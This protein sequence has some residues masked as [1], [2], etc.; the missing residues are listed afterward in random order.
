MWLCHTEMNLSKQ[1]SSSYQI[2]QRIFQFLW[3]KDFIDIKYVLNF[4][5]QFWNLAHTNIKNLFGKFTPICIRKCP[6]ALYTKLQQNNFSYW[7]S[8]TKCL[9]HPT[10]IQF[11]IYK[12]CLLLHSVFDNHAP[13]K[14]CLD[15]N[16]NQNFK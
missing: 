6:K 10:P 7:P 4:I 15:L 14:D 9:S 11:M 16:F 12:H 5:L 1:G 2:K 8:H 13:I 3:I